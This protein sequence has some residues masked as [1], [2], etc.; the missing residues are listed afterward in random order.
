MNRIVQNH[1]TWIPVILF[2][3]LVST[4]C[5]TKQLSHGRP[6]VESPEMLSRK[7]G[8][9]ITTKDYLPLYRE[10]S[11]WLGTPYRGGGNNRRG[12]DCS[13]L[14]VAVYREVYG[15]SLARSAAGI[16]QM[17]CTKVKRKNLREGDL[18]FFHTGGGKRSTPTHVGIYL[19]N[20]RFIHASSSR[21]V[22]V[23]SLSEP[24]YL[25][26]WITGGRVKR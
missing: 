20:N 1:I 23:N 2:A 16:L 12:V 4:S 14:V 25:R 3:I 22:M 26:T 5:R 8:V 7:F 11:G 19:K 6:A 15:K 17:N 13:G 9:R 18:V 10:A 24:Y 21:G